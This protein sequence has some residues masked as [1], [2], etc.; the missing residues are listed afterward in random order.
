[1][2]NLNKTKRQFPIQRWESTIKETSTCNDSTH[3]L[4]EGLNKKENDEKKKD[5]PGYEK[6]AFM[7]CM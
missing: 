7:D 3:K 4:Q 6:G 5:T 2:P 1:M